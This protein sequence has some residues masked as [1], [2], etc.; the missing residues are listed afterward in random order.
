MDDAALEILS[1]ISDE[2]VHAL[3]GEGA[4]R[5]SVQFGLYAALRRELAAAAAATA[6]GG[7]E[8]S[9]ILAFAQAAFR[10]LETLVAH[11]TAA[12][13]DRH[14]DGEWNLRDLLRH[15]IAVE[16]R[17]R[18]QVAYSAARADGDPLAT[19]EALLPCDRLSPPEPEFA[20]SRAG[21]G[22]RLA[23]L[24]GIARAGTDERLRGLTSGALGRPSLWGTT[25]DVRE[26]MHQIA[27]HIIEAILQTERMIAAAAV[28]PEGRRIVRR[29]RAARGLHERR[30]GQDLCGRLD[31]ELEAVAALIGAGAAR[32]L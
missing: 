32:R 30:T 17:Y 22:A 18:E 7:D 20:D 13:L 1:S 31:S 24:L 12:D 4:S 10:E 2:Q 9:A 14:R 29:I 15:A 27:V 19:P 11:R 23:Q 8:I 21:D 3:V 16:L 5:R 26:R 25:H 28:E 6:S